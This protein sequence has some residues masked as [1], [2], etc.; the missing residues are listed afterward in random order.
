M[1]KQ[2]VAAVAILA[3]S[4]T[5]TVALIKSK[6]KAE[7]RAPD[8]TPPLVEY[9]VVR[10]ETQ[11]IPV[12][13]QGTVT[14]KSEAEI[15]PEVAGT[16]TWVSPT[17]TPGGQFRPNEVLLRLDSREYSLA[18]DTARGRVAQ[19]ELKVQQVEAEARQ[20][21]REWERLY[22]DPPPAMAAREPYVEE[23]RASL[24]AA[25]ADMERAELAL[26]R[27]E[28]RAP[29]YSGSVQMIS[30]GVGQFVSP[31]RPVAKVFS[32]E[33]I[34]VR[35]PITDQQR[36][37]TGLPAPGLALAQPLPVKLSALVGGARLEWDAELVR[38][39]ATVDP[40]TRVLYGVAEVLPDANSV[41][42]SVGQFVSAEISG[43]G[44]EGV[45][46]VPRTALRSDNQVY[47]VTPDDRLDI[48]D[49]NVLRRGDE[50]VAVQ[51]GLQ[52]G[53]RVITSLVE[54]PVRDMK[55][56]PRPQPTDNR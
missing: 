15:A 41:N 46:S 44:I 27:T 6:E 29:P 1:S 38:T 2:A 35:L 22:T 4:L 5:A 49:V 18:A 28:V 32:T 42:L 11:V 53:D 12:E 45:I 26:Q 31:G 3:I 13:T 48:R 37:L 8:V 21:I 47:V 39:E 40:R 7:P 30:T 25:R 54:Y 51:S 52:D 56:N 20:A 14:A 17:L 10:A 9:V 36:W 24:A 33:R 19:A 23:A 34:Q 43:R 50:S 16:V 55:V